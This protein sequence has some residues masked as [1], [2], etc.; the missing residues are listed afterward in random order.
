MGLWSKLDTSITFGE[1]GS[2]LKTRNSGLFSYGSDL[3]EINEVSWLTAK[4]GLEFDQY[5][6]GY[7]FS[8]TLKDVQFP[9]AVLRSDL[10]TLTG[11]NFTLADVDSHSYLLLYDESLH[12]LRSQRIEHGLWKFERS[13]SQKF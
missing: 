11:E 8:T 10:T 12:K 1:D 4:D 6:D 5:S 3:M 13:G 2:L 9:F 7:N